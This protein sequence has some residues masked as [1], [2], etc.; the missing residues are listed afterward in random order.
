MWNWTAQIQAKEFVQQF[1]NKCLGD[2]KIALDM[3][4]I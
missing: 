2:V 3:V 1:A 4:P